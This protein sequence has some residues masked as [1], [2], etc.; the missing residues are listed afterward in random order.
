MR[1]A[2]HV[3]GA[4]G[5][6][7]ALYSDNFNRADGDLGGA[8][9]YPSGYAI[10]SNEVATSG[11]ASAPFCVNIA[12]VRTDSNFS[13]IEISTRGDGTSVGVICRA[14]T[15]SG[16]DCYLWR[17]SATAAQLFKVVGGA[18]TALGSAYTVTVASGDVLKISASGSTI[19]GYI[20]GVQRQQVTDTTHAT[21]KYVG[22]RSNGTTTKLDNWTGGDL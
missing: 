12:P 16:Q 4:S 5:A 8:W 7:G 15:V 14:A 21:G 17:C 9:A 3:L 20:N 2:L 19:T 22:I 10:A 18:A 13:Q 1:R 6:Q 11:G